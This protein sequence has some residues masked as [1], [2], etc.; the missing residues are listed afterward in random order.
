MG[1]NTAADPTA[2]FQDGDAPARFGEQASC[3]EARNARSNDEY[4]V[5]SGLVGTGILPQHRCAS[6]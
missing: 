2:R 3:I 1:P 5:L 6:S 4:F